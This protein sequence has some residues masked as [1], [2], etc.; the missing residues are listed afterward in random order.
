VAT[1]WRG[2]PT[3]AERVRAMNNPRLRLVEGDE[4]T[5]TVIFFGEAIEPEEPAED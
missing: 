2:H 4:A 1:R 3:L 5:A